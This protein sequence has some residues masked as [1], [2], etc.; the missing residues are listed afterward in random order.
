[1]L[2]YALHATTMNRDSDPDADIDFELFDAGPET[3]ASSDG[4]R[5][6]ATDGGDECGD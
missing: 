4:Q 2:A 1:L 5:R 6:R 3:Q